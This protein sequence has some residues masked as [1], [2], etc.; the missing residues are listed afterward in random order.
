[1]PVSLWL[2]WTHPLVFFGALA[3]ALVVM[4]ATIWV[5]MKFLRRLARRVAGWFGAAQPS[6]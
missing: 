1:V 6:T 5:L 2:S 3:I 4:V